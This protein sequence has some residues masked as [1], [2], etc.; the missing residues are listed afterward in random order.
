M[1]EPTDVLIIGSGPAGCAAAATC[2]KEGLKVTM[3]T[4]HRDHNLLDMAAPEPLESIHPG[5]LSLLHKIGLAGTETRA[6]KS[7]YDGIY[8]GGNYSALGHDA[9][10]PWLGLHL[11]RRIFNAQLLQRMKGMG[12]EIRFET[13]VDDLILED[14]KVIG[15]KTPTEELFAPYVIDASG[16]K[17]V[18]GKKL[19]FTSRFFSPPLACWTGVSA[20]FD[21]YP[22][23]SRSSHFYA[24]PNGWT[25]LAPYPPHYCSWTRLSIKGEKDLSQP[26]E[27]KDYHVF[28]KVQFANMRWRMYRPVCREGVVLCGD[29]AGI[30]D[31]AAGQG[32]LNAL[33]S[34]IEAGKTVVSCIQQPDFAAYHLA[35][36]DDWFVSQFEE[37]V[38]KLGEYYREHGISINTDS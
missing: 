38:R 5:V 2:L 10:G 27:I 15:L 25:W 6:T 22:F 14:K 20:I 28:G 12:V 3:I 24:N 21:I 9:D 7:T 23:D 11:N 18:A 31:P 35:Q 16:K 29:A 13:K 33:W 1:T 34:G 17:A 19:K 36:Y 4:E 8:S 30:L 37:K 26:Q 32:I